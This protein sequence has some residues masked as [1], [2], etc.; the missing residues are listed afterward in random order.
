MNDLIAKLLTAKGRL[1][2]YGVAAAVSALALIYE[3]LTPAQAAGWLAVA[4]AVLGIAA[5]AVAMKHITP[6]AP[7]EPVDE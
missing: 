6:D 3:L 7:K 1:W 4:A 2:L 5:P